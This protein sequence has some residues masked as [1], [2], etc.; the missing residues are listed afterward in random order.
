MKR[1][2]DMAL[3]WVRFN[4][5]GEG[6]R[7]S[8]THAKHA[9][10]GPIYYSNGWPIA[11]LVM[12]P[13][14]NYACLNKHYVHPANPTDWA[15]DGGPHVVLNLS[16][17]DVA[18]F[19]SYDGDWLPDAQLHERLRN[20]WAMIASAQVERAKEMAFTQLVTG[21]SSSSTQGMQS[22]LRAMLASV[23]KEY[24]KYNAAFQLGWRSFPT[25]FKA[26]LEA[27]IENRK[28]IYFSKKETEKRER[29]AARAG[30]KKAFGLDNKE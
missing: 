25:I 28:R 26:E 14:G 15:S 23:T 7:K 13:G 5:R 3:R 18:T 16:V 17:P 6:L 20:L 4:V 29:I 19:S 22:V 9:Y 30:A 1:R 21:D 8:S 27:T 11:R 10:T 12:L 2:D 24:E